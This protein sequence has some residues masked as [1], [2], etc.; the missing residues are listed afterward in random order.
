M[1]SVKLGS[2]TLNFCRAHWLTADLAAAAAS[3]P[4]TPPRPS[5][6]ILHFLCVVVLLL[7]F[8]LLVDIVEVALVN[9]SVRASK[10]IKY[11]TL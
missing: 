1:H 10:I 11:L 2:D 3:S 4:S 5:A 7:L 9:F 8:L 6:S